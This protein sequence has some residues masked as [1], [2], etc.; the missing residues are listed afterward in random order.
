[1]A[2]AYNIDGKRFGRIVAL[3]HSYTTIGKKDRKQYYECICDC[4]NR[5]VISKGNLLIGDTT[6]CGC[7]QRERTSLA[8]KT[9]GGS[10]TG[11]YDIWCNIKERCTNNEN[12]GYKNYGGRGIKI[13]SEW[14]SSFESFKIYMGPKP[15][16][17]HTVDRINNNGNYEPGNCRWATRK[18]QCRNFRRNRFFEIN[19]ERKTLAEWCEIYKLPQ[20]NV[21]QRIR[22]LGWSIEEALEIKFRKRWS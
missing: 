1:M 21:G 6:S 19:G 20:Y 14:F 5:K 9:H 22:K 4:G 17:S 2:K 15:S 7:V 8:S 3:W 16:P 11:L 18:E 12:P 13:C 10:R